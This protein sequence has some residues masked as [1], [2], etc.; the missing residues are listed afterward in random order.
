MRKLKSLIA[1]SLAFFLW[2]LIRLPFPE[3][4]PHPMFAYIYAVLEMRKDPEETKNF[5]RLRIKA[6]I[7]GLLTGLFFLSIALRLGISGQTDHPAV[8]GEFITILAACLV[9]LLVSD[10]LHCESFCG[11]ATIITV[12]CMIGTRNKNPYLYAVMRT[13][14]TLIGVGAATF[15]NLFIANPERKK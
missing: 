4:E 1:V 15:V 7:I 2:F 3:L 13:L 14:Q 10:V 9:S 12:M 8:L 11:I 5:S 6:T